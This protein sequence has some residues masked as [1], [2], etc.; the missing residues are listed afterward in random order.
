[1]P[2]IGQAT[3]GAA[4]SQVIVRFTL[5]IIVLGVFATFGTIGFSRSLA[6]LLWMSI[7]ISVVAGTLR[8]ETVLAPNLNYWDEAVAYGALYC[9]TLLFATSHSV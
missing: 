9:L 2:P 1:M 5:R 4:N 6:A 8:R 7:I 3:A